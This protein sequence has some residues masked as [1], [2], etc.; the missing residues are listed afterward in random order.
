MLSLVNVS[1]FITGYIYNMV[2]SIWSEIW[3]TVV[4]GWHQSLQIRMERDRKLKPFLQ[5]MLHSKSCCFLPGQTHHMCAPLSIMTDDV[6]WDTYVYCMCVVHLLHCAALPIMTDSNIGDISSDQA[7]ML[8]PW[9]KVDSFCVQWSCSPSFCHTAGGATP[10][11]VKW[12]KPD[13]VFS[14]VTL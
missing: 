12:I 1:I 11:Q 8:T 4:V 14:N 3:P 5:T 10:M 7:N 6:I 2:L 9:I 13:L